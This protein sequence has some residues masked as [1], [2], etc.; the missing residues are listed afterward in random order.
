ME[1]KIVYATPEQ[2]EKVAERVAGEFPVSF[3]VLA[4]NEEKAKELIE[5]RKDHESE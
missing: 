3:N 5:E 1:K 2:V 4:G